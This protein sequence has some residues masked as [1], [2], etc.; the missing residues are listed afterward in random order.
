MPDFPR[1]EISTAK[2]PAGWMKHCGNEHESL[3]LTP[4]EIE[5]KHTPFMKVK[6]YQSYTLRI[7]ICR[8][9]W[10]SP[11]ILFWGWDCNHQS[12]SREGSGFLGKYIYIYNYIYIYMSCGRNYV[13]GELAMSKLGGPLSVVKVFTIWNDQGFRGFHCGGVLISCQPWVACWPR[14]VKQVKHSTIHG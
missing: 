5:D 3:M 14:S 7:Q 10:I 1:S 4:N 12:Y 11:I 13:H 6:P 2:N 9:K 8:K